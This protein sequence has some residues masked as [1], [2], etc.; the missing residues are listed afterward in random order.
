MVLRRE[1][2]ANF[3]SR[4]Y[5]NFGENIL[6][7]GILSESFIAHMVKEHGTT[8]DTRFIDLSCFHVVMII[9]LISIHRD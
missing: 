6:K 3:Q 9:L 5:E 8:N 7:M 2:C 1:S 4:V